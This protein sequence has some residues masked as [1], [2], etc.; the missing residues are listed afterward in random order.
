MKKILYI[1]IGLLALGLLAGVL[2]YVKP[3]FVSDFLFKTSLS[4]EEKQ[5]PNLTFKRFSTWN[6]NLMEALAIKN[7]NPDKAIEKFSLSLNETNMPTLKSRI[8]FNIVDSYQ[9]QK[10][11]LPAVELLKDI[12]SNKDYEESMRSKAIERISIIYFLPDN[13]YGK[14]NAEIFKSIFD[15][16]RFG[17]FKSNVWGESSLNLLNYGQGL[18][19]LAISAARIAY[20]EATY[21]KYGRSDGIPS[22]E[23]KTM[24][25]SIDKASITKSV[26]Y[27]KEDKIIESLHQGNN[28][29]E[30]I[31]NRRDAN[32]REVKD[33]E[34]SYQLL[35]TAAIARANSSRIN[36]ELGDASSNYE[37][38]L[39]LTKDFPQ[40]EPVVYLLYLIDIVDK[41]TV[42]A[43]DPKAEELVSRMIESQ[44]KNKSKA[45]I[46]LLKKVDI[47]EQITK[48]APNFSSL[49]EN[50]N[51]K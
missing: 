15:D 27:E 32:Q 14:L 17:Q 29:I 20:I 18:Y 37:K 36:S 22:G 2:I 39:L 7:L 45:F 34:L 38:A 44:E 6:K 11:Y 13:F 31:K 4:T 1:A 24:S 8:E 10:N 46:S 33:L 25:K 30:N 26:I 5:S 43:P 49:I 21:I 28:Y 42:F 51:K 9:R 19:P 35:K 3:V 41:K 16:E 23:F 50:N 40:T 12:A 47:T 48:V